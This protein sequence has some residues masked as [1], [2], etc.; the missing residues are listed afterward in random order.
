MSGFDNTYFEDHRYLLELSTF[1]EPKS[2]YVFDYTFQSVDDEI[3]KYEQWEEFLT[4]LSQ[5]MGRSSAPCTIGIPSSGGTVHFYSNRPTSTKTNSL[6]TSTTISTTT[7]LSTVETSSICI[8][9]NV[10]YLRLQHAPL[11]G[12]PWAAADH[13]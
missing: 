2:Q 10:H 3:S 8:K 1:L 13:E 12:T 9:K 7:L 5:S 6:I 4:D 11:G